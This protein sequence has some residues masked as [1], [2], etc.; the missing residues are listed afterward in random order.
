MSVVELFAALDGWSEA[1]GARRDQ[2]M[3]RD[4][5]EKLMERYPD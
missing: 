5:L 4:E 1:N 3:T 2:G